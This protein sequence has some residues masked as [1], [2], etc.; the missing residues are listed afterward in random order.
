[1]Q[2]ASEWPR[3]DFRGISLATRLVG[4]FPGFMPS[5][6]IDR[7]SRA[8]A[9][10]GNADQR[11][12]EDR[13]PMPFGPLAAFARFPVLPPAGVATDRLQ[14]LPRREKSGLPDPCPDYRR[15][16]PCLPMPFRSPSTM[17][18]ARATGKT[19]PANAEEAKEMRAAGSRKDRMTKISLQALLPAPVTERGSVSSQGI[20][21]EKPFF[22]RPPLPKAKVLSIDCPFVGLI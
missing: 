21:S 1:M 8:E 18:A 6:E 3:D 2:F 5:L 14:T 10:F 17:P 7:A 19:A 4:Q 16:S 12:A 20:K 22:Y 9:V 13:H 15:V 11:L